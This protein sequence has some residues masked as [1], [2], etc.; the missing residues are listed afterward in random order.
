[1]KKTTI[2]SIA[3]MMTA[4]SFGVSFENIKFNQE[5]D[6][7]AVKALTS[8]N[9]GSLYMVAGMNEMDIP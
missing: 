5:I 7:N 1:M 9:D 4:I 8:N 3:I 6:T 2:I